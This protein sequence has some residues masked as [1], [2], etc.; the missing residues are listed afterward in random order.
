MKKIAY[1]V[2]AGLL[3]LSSCLAS[4]S[5]QSKLDEKMIEV[6]KKM[7]TANK[8]YSIKSI[9]IINKKAVDDKWKMY[10]FDISLID[11]RNKKP[12]KTPMVVFTD[13]KYETNSL[14]NM[15]TGIRFETQEKIRLQNIK[16]RADK[17]TI[18]TFEKSFKLDDKYYNKEHLISGELNAKNKVVIISD[19]LCIACI[20]MF[21]SVYKSLKSKKDVAVFY[22]HYPLK[23]LH[24]TAE[25]VSKAMMLAK[26]DGIKDIELKV[27]KANFNKL[28]DVYKMKDN[29]VAL[30]TFNTTFKTNY[31]ISDINNHS[32]DLDMEIGKDI[33]LKGTPSVVF[34]GEI[35][36][37][38][39]KL[40]K[41]L[42][43]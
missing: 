43:K 11:N 8:N 38:R 20:N 7:I 40:S 16:K 28:F 17:L 34:N 22:Y 29:Q 12:L 25:T 4:T 9:E 1:I 6:Q 33:R 41:F 10:T 31:S 26:Q 42:V 24:P 19:P 32:V 2:G 23:M 35:Y 36:E 37:A 21:P 5:S 15:E 39:K 27:Y 13:G 30:D 3:G 14:M 18:K